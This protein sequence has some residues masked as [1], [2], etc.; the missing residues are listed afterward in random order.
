MAPL[1]RRS[2]K[3]QFH[4]SAPIKSNGVTH[5]DIRMPSAPWRIR[6]VQPTITRQFR[7]QVKTILRRQRKEALEDDVRKDQMEI[8]PVQDEGSRRTAETPM[9]SSSSIVALGGTPYKSGAQ[10]QESGNPFINF[11]DLRYP[12]SSTKGKGKARQPSAA[13]ARLPS[14]PLADTRDSSDSSP[15]PPTPTPP[16][17]TP[18][19]ARSASQT[20]G[21][22]TTV[23]STTKDLD[24]GG[25]A[26]WTPYGPKTGRPTFIRKE[27]I[28]ST[29]EDCV[30]PFWEC[31]SRTPLASPPE[32]SDR[33]E[34]VLGDIFCN[35]V[36]GVDMPQMWL[37][38]M[39]GS[40]MPYWEPIVEGELRDDG[41]R[42]YITP[43]KKHPSWV[44][45]HWCLKQIIKKQKTMAQI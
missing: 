36:A 32:L 33:P 16:P 1:R 23:T 10:S 25:A 2:S 42:L 39:S 30:T 7:K 17:R 31:H 34:L 3:F 37:W 6:D 45:S 26:V 8:D 29:T 35:Y 18:R 11:K 43:K 14:A 19:R 9:A 13:L 12:T 22:G 41:R 27:R 24:R 28:S 4:Y 38:T 44:K 5:L 21:V 20:S 15:E 40:K